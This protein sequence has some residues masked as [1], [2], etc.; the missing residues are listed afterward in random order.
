MKQ[1]LSKFEVAMG[2][3]LIVGGILFMFVQPY[4][5]SR[6]YNKLTGAS[7]TWFDALWTELRV[8]DNVKK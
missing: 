8:M 7:T 2:I 6:T 4:M 5:E 3:A 1:K